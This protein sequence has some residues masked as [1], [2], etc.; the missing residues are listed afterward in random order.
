ME[1]QKSAI[2]FCGAGPGD[3]D[4]ITVKGMRALESADLVLYAGSLVPEAVLAWAPEG[5]RRISSAGMDLEEIIS[6]M[7]EA[8]HGGRKVV[9]LHTGDPSL[10]GAVREQ[11]EALRA[12]RIPCRVIPGVTAAFAAAAAMG[13][14]Y[15]V[16][17]KTQTLI[18][19]RM[20]GRTPVPDAENLEALARH[21]A[22]MV[23]YLSMSLIE[24]LTRLLSAAYGADA[25]CA[26]ASRVSRPEE[27]IVFTRVGRLSE[28]ARAEG[29]H[30]LAII[31]VGPALENFQS[32]DVLR[33]KLY[34]KDFRHAYRGGQ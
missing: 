6:T 26:V 30:R 19:T 11:M 20:A 28:T 16:P 10:Y 15:T 17:E 29:I 34:H 4:L 25:A 2:T 27:K 8:Y 23:I 18:F 5:A 12:R 33:S 22:S 21:G 13:I 3:P 1:P 14:A 9:R 32:S 31:I 24:A 7:A